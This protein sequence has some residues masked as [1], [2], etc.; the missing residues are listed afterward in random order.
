[1]E[2]RKGGKVLFKALSKAS[3]LSG[4]CRHFREAAGAICWDKREGSATIKAYIEKIIKPVLNSTLGS[5]DLTKNEIKQL[6]LLNGGTKPARAKPG[7]S[8]KA[9]E[10]YIADMRKTASLTT[11]N[12]MTHEDNDVKDE[13]QDLDL[14]MEYEEM[15]LAQG[16]HYQEPTDPGRDMDHSPT[17]D[18]LYENWDELIRDEPVRDEPI[19]PNADIEEECTAAEVKNTTPPRFIFCC[20]EAPFLQSMT[21]Q[22]ALM[23]SLVNMSDPRNQ[24]P[25]RQVEVLAIRD[26][27]QVTVDHFTEIFGYEPI[28]YEGSNYITEYCNIQDQYDL[29]FEEDATQLRR[30][31]RWEGTIFDWEQANVEDDPCF[32]RMTQLFFR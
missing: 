23:H 26:A 19:A 1:M 3:T 15:S 22:Q 27:L 30:L 21:E 16:D 24:I 5:R 17:N 14:E 2:V 9:K 20:T 10:K 6:R 18:E 4:R 13:K 12:I 25:K 32:G 11:P 29:I 28:V 8:Q 7:T 31:G